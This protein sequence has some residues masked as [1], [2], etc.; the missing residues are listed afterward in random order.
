MYRV[1]A[2]ETIR[3]K[4]L[5]LRQKHKAVFCVMIGIEVLI[6]LFLLLGY[7]G[8]KRKGEDA[9]D[10]G[11]RAEDFLSDNISNEDGWSV[12]L[13]QVE[14]GEEGSVCILY[15]P[16]VSLPAGDY[17]LVI[18]YDCESEQRVKPY[19][20]GFDENYIEAN[21]INLEEDLHSTSYDFRLTAPVEKFEIRF[22]Y[23][24]QGVLRINEVKLLRNLN[25]YKKLACPAETPYGIRR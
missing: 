22:F 15:G 2:M 17:T 21:S 7:I 19:A 11:I 10:T 1:S 6:I 23:D 5:L 8:E 16:F 18:A 20:S 12:E 3:G 13:D 9:F 4:L 25:K 24:G 14:I